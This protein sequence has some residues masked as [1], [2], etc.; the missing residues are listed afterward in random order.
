MHF[1]RLL[2]KHAFKL[3]LGLKAQR[4]TKCGWWWKWFLLN[5]ISI[6]PRYG[7]FTWNRDSRFVVA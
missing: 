5:E 6:Y 2:S 4:D 7:M 1:L 3:A